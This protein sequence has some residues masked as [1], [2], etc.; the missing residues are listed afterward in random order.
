MTG[1]PTCTCAAGA[2]MKHIQSINQRHIDLS[3][4]GSADDLQWWS[5]NADHLLCVGENLQ[6]KHSEADFVRVHE[7]CERAG[8]KF[9]K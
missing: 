5:L 7:E 4:N 1:K 3:A 2:K 6:I 9:H 8:K